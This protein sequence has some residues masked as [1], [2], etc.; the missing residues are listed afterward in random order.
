ME[1]SGFP[2]E[3]VV[4]MAGEELLVRA[5]GAIALTAP[6]TGAIADVLGRKR[7]IVTAADERARL[8]HFVADKAG[9][10]RA[11]AS[12]VRVAGFFHDV[13]RVAVPNGI[14]TVLPVPNATVYIPAEPNTALP[15]FFEGVA[16]NNPASC[17]RCEDEKLVADGQSVLAAAVTNYAA[18]TSGV[19][20]VEPFLDDAIKNS[21]ENNPPASAPQ[22]PRAAPRTSP[23]PPPA[24]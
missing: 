15:S 19:M 22:A 14:A 7:V 9:C 5:L 17:G 21:P 13:G 4:G 8:D 3:R 23:T 12:E 24:P 2:R 1:T 18:Y 16:A 6:F 11:E 10:S 20:G